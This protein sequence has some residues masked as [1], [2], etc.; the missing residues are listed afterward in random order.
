MDNKIV[1]NFING[2]LFFSTF[3]VALIIFIAIINYIL[4]TIYSINANVKEYTYNS[5]PFFKLNQIYNYMLINYVYLLNNNKN[6]KYAKS[7]EGYYLI[8]NLNKPDNTFEILK[9]SENCIDEK[10]LCIDKYIPIPEKLVQLDNISKIDESL[11]KEIIDESDSYFTKYVYYN[12]ISY[13]KKQIIKNGIDKYVYILYDHND[14]Y[15]IY[16]K[17]YK[18]DE[19]V[20]LIDNILKI[21][22]NL[23]NFTKSHDRK[24]SDL[25]ILFNNKL[26][27]LLF[28]II[29]IIFFVIILIIIINILTDLFNIIITNQDY[30]SS[31]NIIKI[32]YEENHY[33]F[34][35]I[36]V[37]VIYCIFHSILYYYL[38]IN[39]VYN[40]VYNKYLELI[41][42][43]EYI[44]S[45]I[46]ENILKYENN[47][48]SK[49]LDHFKLLSKGGDTT[50]K[51]NTII[52]F[53][54]NIPINIQLENY[55]KKI[56]RLINLFNLDNDSY[57][58]NYIVNIIDNL[59]LKIYNGD[60]YN[61]QNDEHQII[62]ISFLLIIYI[63]FVNNN[64]DDP[65]IIIKLN[66][67]LF[68]ENIRVGDDDIDID[69]EYT[70]TLRSLLYNNINIDSIEKDLENIKEAL[71]K[72]SK[73]LKYKLFNNS[74][75]VYDTLLTKNIKSFVE[76]I[77]EGEKSLDFFLPVYFI[78]LYM[79]LEM[80]IGCISLIIL[81]TY[82]VKPQYES[83]EMKKFIEKVNIIILVIISEVEGAV[84]G[85]I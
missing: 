58:I 44:K 66:K 9:K 65:Y 72:K 49:I 51:R 6:I 33:I 84:Q 45:I 53:K 79:A 54:S 68:G 40:N 77:K 48:Y 55:N 61:I 23:F 5:F 17:Y 36:V 26:Y 3:I 35:A 43:D 37:I 21:P 30:T 15:Y 8:K 28:L 39:N 56:L 73:E 29:F 78:N 16:C 32:L 31:T 25:Y 63:Y 14:E 7:D 50:I 62:A 59:A 20:S 19:E 13:I 46:G 27:E 42:I 4:Y 64:K 52:D 80:L 85:I 67:L 71:K 83:E 10:N 11:K 12:D 57:Y 82:F 74:H 76:K 41:K 47:N 34:I 60:K 70:L 1:I 69:I 18:I 22:Y 81:L 24:T 38:F 75:A 2:L